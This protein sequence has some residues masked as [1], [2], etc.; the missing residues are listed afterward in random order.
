LEN[1]NTRSVITGSSG[2]LA[3]NVRSLRFQFGGDLVAG[4]AGYREIDVI[5]IASVPEPSAAL[6]TLLSTAALLRR[7]R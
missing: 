4:F 7:R 3:T 2:I 6:L 1:V 5:G